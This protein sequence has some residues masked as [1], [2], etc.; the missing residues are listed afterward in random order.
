VQTVEQVMSRAVITV[1]PDTSISEV[2]RLL[3][4]KGIS[5]LPVVDDDGHV[6]GVV[7]EGDLVVKE[8]HPRPPLS[9]RPLARNTEAKAIRRK[10]DATTAGEAMTSPALTIEPYRAIRAAAEI[11]TE[12]HVNR[13][14]VVGAAGELL[15]IVTRADLV[16]AFVRSDEEL[17]EAIRSEVLIR[18]M[19][20][21]PDTFTVRVE[22]GT[23]YITGS[24][25]KRSTAEVTRRLLAMV[26][27]VLAVEADITWTEDDGGVTAP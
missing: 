13:L 2:A 17:T 3:V 5:G 1:A 9:R 8:A 6:L 20:L 16:R 11:M 7:S 25:I 4:E 15:G 18:E 22:R 19:W 14:P 10:V 23:A 26:P 27:G 21:D 12:H 24:V